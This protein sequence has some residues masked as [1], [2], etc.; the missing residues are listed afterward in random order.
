MTP[1]ET[2]TAALNRANLTAEHR[3]LVAFSGGLDS[4]VLVDLLH[5]ARTVGGP[6]P[7]LIH[8]DHGARPDSGEDAHFCRDFARSRGLKIDVEQLRPAP[9]LDAPKTQQ[10]YRSRRLAAIARCAISRGIEVIA[11]G[12][13]S[14][15]RVESFLLNLTRGAGIRGLTTMSA[16]TPFPFGAPRLRLIRP[17]LDLRRSELQNYA[18]RHDLRWITDPTNQTDA[19]A[20]NRVRHHLLP[21]LDALQ[22]GVPGVLRSI[23]NLE[24]EARS[25]ETHTETL[26]QQASLFTTGIGAW[27]FDREIL[28]SAPMATVAHLFLSLEPSLDRKS[29]RRIRNAICEPFDPSVRHLT[30]S[31]CMI[32]VVRDRVVF[33]RSNERGARDILERCA[34]P[35]SLTPFKGGDAPFFRS[36]IRWKLLDSIPDE[37]TPW[38]AYFN[39]DA[40]ERPLFISGVRAGARL[41]R[42]RD[43]RV[44][45]Q[46]LTKLLSTFCVDSDIRW[47]WPTLYDRSGNLLWAA[48]LPRGCAAKPGPDCP[49]VWRVEVIPAEDVIKILQSQRN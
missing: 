34:E 27:E 25:L 47:R 38:V 35:I 48:G 45:H 2:V 1:I 36:Q 28:R 39:A 32:T 43:G 19:Y 13:H 23:D 21:D 30:L 37:I 14:D 22:G 16:E 5:R 4:T 18:E 31:N 29:L 24:S 42:S 46:K 15:D 12:H 7:E 11:L 3:I 8:V 10:Q 40:L 6:L 49:A 33:E 20:R 17:L 26:R 9:Q 44:Y 41:R